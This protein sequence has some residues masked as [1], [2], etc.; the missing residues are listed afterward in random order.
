MCCQILKPKV[1]AHFNSAGVSCT[2]EYHQDPQCLLHL[3]EFLYPLAQ[4]LNERMHF[5]TSLL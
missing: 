1:P 3:S 2:A 5:G 4:S